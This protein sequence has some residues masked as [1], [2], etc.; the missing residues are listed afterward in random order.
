MAR[1]AGKLLSDT[2]GGMMLRVGLV[3]VLLLLS[4]LVW[5]SERVVSLGGSVTE[6]IFAL[7]EGERLVATD[8]SSLYPE[9]ATRLPQVGY[10]RNL[11][12]EGILSQRPDLLIVSENAGPPETLSRISDMGVPTVAVSDDP[13]IDSLY[14][15]VSQIATALG[16]PEAGRQLQAEIQTSM[17]ALSG[18]APTG[19]RAL[20]VLH[21]GGPLMSAGA[22]T[23]ADALLR[24]SGLENVAAGTRGYRPL[25][26]EALPALAPDLII[27][28]TTSADSAGGMDAFGER[29]GVAATPAGKA[30]R[31]VAIDDL[32]LLGMGP[33]VAEAVRQLRAAAD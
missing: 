5:A 33:R 25:T 7:G 31:V 13:G 20:V 12:L 18:V 23:S 19:R 6:I 28:T 26:E 22:G 21:R 3:L 1:L 11:S 30:G 10:Y 16:V 2:A 17:A 29:P 32:L 4:P 14:E 8:A 24:L 27:T 9:A 15:R